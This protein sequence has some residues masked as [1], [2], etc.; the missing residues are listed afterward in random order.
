[1]LEPS[2]YDSSLSFPDLLARRLADSSASFISLK[3]YPLRSKRFHEQVNTAMLPLFER[4]IDA[5]RHVLGS[6][7]E[8]GS[9]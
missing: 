4:A 7:L 1:M 2:L 6:H 3:N 8:T 9:Q 5:V